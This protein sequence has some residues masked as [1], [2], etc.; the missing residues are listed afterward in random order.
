MIS[1]ST[2]QFGDLSCRL[3]PHLQ[4]TIPGKTLK[5]ILAQELSEGSIKLSQIMGLRGDFVQ[6]RSGHCFNDFLLKSTVHTRDS[7]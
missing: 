3:I 1:G 4:H 7:A 2:T 5:N 6:R